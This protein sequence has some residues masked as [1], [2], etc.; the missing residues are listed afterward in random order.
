M[1]IGISGKM[2][3]GKSTVGKIIQYLTAGHHL[4]VSN[5]KVTYPRP[6]MEEIVE[7][8][9]FPEPFEQGKDPWEIKM[10]AYAVKQIASILTGIHVNDF[11]K[12][13]VKNRTLG[14]EWGPNPITV[15]ELLQKIGTDAMRN[16]VHPNVWIN[17]LFS[18]YRSSTADSF[19]MSTYDAGNGCY[20]TLKD[21]PIHESYKFPK[22]IITDVRFPNEVDAILERGGIVLRLERGV[23][24]RYPE[25]WKEFQKQDQWD[26]W[27]EFLISRGM[28]EK[29]YH[30]SEEALNT[31][32]FNPLH[33]IDS[34]GTIGSLVEQVREILISNKIL[35]EDK[36]TST[37]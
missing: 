33:I 2:Q 25:L 15:R 9:L 14:D 23:E 35:N 17:A 24:F 3:S 27:D 13:S 5:G 19:G 7:D 21:H 29:V 12:I 8:I 22:W 37:V 20:F 31:Y 10:Y 26:E 1:I 28:L 11:E 30:P 18:T 36:R 4:E 6:T 16:M 32:P 34:N